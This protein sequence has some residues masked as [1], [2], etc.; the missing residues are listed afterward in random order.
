[1]A[2]T[3][4]QRG[5]THT[6]L[7]PQRWSKKDFKF[8]FAKNPLLPFMGT[9]EDSIIQVNKDFIKE[10]GD[11]ITF[12]LRAL[13]TGDGQGDDG[14]YSGNSEAMTFYNMDVQLHERGHSVQLSGNMTEQAAY[15]K[16][17]PKGMAALREWSGLVDAADIIA[18]LSGLVTKKHIAGCR[19]GEN[20]VD[21]SSAQISTVNQTS[22]S[23]SATATRWFGGGQNSSGTVTRVATDALITSTTNHLFGTD[24]IE[25]VHR[26]AVKEVDGSGNAV[27][28]LRPV[29]IDG[30]SYYLML[31]D[32][33]Q[34]KQ[35]QNDT[36]WKA[37]T[38]NALPRSVKENWIFSGADGVWDGVVIKTVDKLHRRTGA[39]GITADEF[40]DTTGDA[41]YNGITVARALFLGC[42]AACLAWGK[43]PVW[44]TGY[45]DPPHNT[46]YT[47]HTDKIY[48]VKKSVFNSVEHGC[49]CVDTA[50]IA[51]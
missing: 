12:A 26:M 42:Q 18:A 27:N 31:I 30:M 28:P 50:V 33:Y 39:G 22:L 6:N 1:M 14:T 32:Q 16:L 19:T 2:S 51:D 9:G 36:K 3:T 47:V 17:R 8:A 49:I 5:S 34:K 41:C 15:D 44:K 45:N 23:K 24:V 10:Q 40:F 43:M 13:L 46:K 25:Y 11:K 29:V 35:L 37:A 4:F 7:V 48:G 38:Q 21:A 20:A